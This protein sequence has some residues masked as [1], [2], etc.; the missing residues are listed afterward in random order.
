MNDGT[1]PAGLPAAGA[2]PAGGAP[3]P[4][5]A[6]PPAGGAPPAPGAPAPEAKWWDALPGIAPEA[7]EYLGVKNPKDV[8]EWTKSYRELEGKITAKG[9]LVPAADAPAEEWAKFYKAVPGFPEGPDK[10]N[11]PVAPGATP[12][13]FEKRWETAMRPAFHK[14]GLTQQQVAIL[15]N[16][17]YM[18]FATAEMKALKDADAQKGAEDERARDDFLKTLGGEKP[19]SDKERLEFVALGQRAVQDLLKDAPAELR[20]AILTAVNEKTGTPAFLKLFGE[21]GKRFYREGSG[22]LN[23]G[24]QPGQM[25]GAQAAHE[26]N[27]MK[28]DPN[29]RKILADK[30]HPQYK[31][32]LQKW[33]DLIE[34]VGRE[35]DKQRAAAA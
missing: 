32:T 33:N 9:L 31:A 8:N 27:N 17:G 15:I 13:E 22:A 14:A 5:P 20:A 35:E 25:T 2:P 30:S 23:P 11:V 16:D 21:I 10:Y 26:L 12:T 4:P 19:V 1:P 28:A 24:A 3:A 7:K 34:A 29:A 18:P 6:A